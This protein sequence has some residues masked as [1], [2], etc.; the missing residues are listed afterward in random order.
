[1]IALVFSLGLLHELC[2]VAWV[3]AVTRDSPWRAAGA[4]VLL[5]SF[6]LA[7]VVGVL[8]GGHVFARAAALVLG[9]GAGSWVAVWCGARRRG[10]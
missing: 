3:R 4:T 6:G 2:W 10:G 5:G 7:G 8:D 9:Y 1:M